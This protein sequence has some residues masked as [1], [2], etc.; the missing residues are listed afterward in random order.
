VAVPSIGAFLVADRHR[1]TPRKGCGNR[2]W[3]IG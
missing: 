3:P 2:G 1:I